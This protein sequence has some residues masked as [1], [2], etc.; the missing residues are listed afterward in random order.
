MYV[1]PIKLIRRS[2]T[3]ALLIIGLALSVYI[4]VSLAT[5]KKE[6]AFDLST[7]PS[8]ALGDWIFRKGS[9]PESQIIEA[10]SQGEFSHIGVIV[11]LTPQPLVIHATTDDNPHLPNQVILSTLEDFISPA[12]AKY[13]AI[14]RLEHTTDFQ[15]QRVITWLLEQQGQPFVLT[16][17]ERSPLYC[18]TLILEAL[19]QAQITIAPQWQHI[20]APLLKGEYLFPRAFAELPHLAWQYHSLNQRN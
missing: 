5:P 7:L 8:L 18:T 3:G 14:A 20:N 11:S 16:T 10:L 19:N 13:F 1:L 9:A 17:R 4:V 2:L 6:L 12:L 15:Q